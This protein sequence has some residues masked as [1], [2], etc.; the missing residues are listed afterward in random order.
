M[1]AALA[2]I[3]PT[4]Q[5]S[6]A[7]VP[8]ELRLTGADLVVVGKIDRLTDNFKV[9]ERMHDVGAITVQRVLKGPANLKEAQVAWPGKARFAL[10]T[11]I[12]YR[13]GQQGVWILTRDAK[14]P[15]VYRASYPTDFQPPANLPDILAALK[16]LA[17]MKW[18]PA[19]AGLQMAVLVEQRDMRRARVQAGGKPVKT[20]A[21]ASVY[22]MARNTTGKPMH[23]ANY[24][25]DEPLKLVFTGPDGKPIPVKLYGARPPKPPPLAKHNLIGLP[26]GEMRAFSYG[27]GLPVIKRPGKYQVTISYANDRDGG[28]LVASTVWRGKLTAPMLEFSVAP[29]K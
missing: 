3:I 8:L 18:S 26:P 1:A 14:Q 4:T 15:N 25:F 5:A 17:T 11:D 27:L 23:V 10:S 19:K 9:G 22:L 29:A 16:K 2:V 21:R 7:Y 13:V 24:R 6:W 20:L 12:R 28:K